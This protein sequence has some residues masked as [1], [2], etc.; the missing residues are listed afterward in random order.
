VELV[1]L[2]AAVVSVVVGSGGATVVICYWLWLRFCRD[3]HDKAVE[4]GQDPDPERIIQ[5]A[6]LGR[7]S[8][9]PKPPELPAA[10][11]SSDKSL[12]A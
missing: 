4:R 3:M 6:R 2:I 5:A 1:P 12:A 10:P 9:L 8:S 11:E 7:P